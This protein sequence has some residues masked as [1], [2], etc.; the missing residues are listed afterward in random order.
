[1]K[2]L[3]Y[4]ALSNQYGE[5][6][7][8]DGVSKKVFAQCRALESNGFHVNLLA[9]GDDGIYLEDLQNSV[10][11][12]R[13]SIKTKRRRY[14][15]F[16]EATRII[17]ANRIEILYIRYPYCDLAFLKLLKK[18][19]SKV[20]VYV[21]IPSYPIERF[22]VA[23][24]FG[25]FYL[26]KIDKLFAP[27]M[28]K[29]VWEFRIIGSKISYLYGVRCKNILNGIDCNE[30]PIKKIDVKDEEIKLLAVSRMN[31]YHGYDRLLRGLADYYKKEH[32]KRVSLLMVGDGVMKD[33]W[34]ELADSIGIAQYVEF[35]GSKK[36]NELDRFFDIAHIAIDSLG[37]HRVG[38][39]VA[40]TLKSR[41]YCARGIPFVSA[42]SVMGFAED[43]PFIIKSPADE[44]NIDV[45]GLVG[46]YNKMVK[47]Y[48]NY[49]VEMR[50]YAEENLSWDAQMNLCGMNNV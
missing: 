33:K 15:I 26:S 23:S 50:Q 48:P 5:N 34:L 14:S 28:K 37:L 32:G 36:K 42:T 35:T 20:K 27:F 1:M 22:G 49:S 8:S 45:A 9:Y 17:V 41:E 38:F 7:D 29:Y 43:F 10:C 39:N 46:S 3:L 19:K 4:L 16:A 18:A 11:E 21:E 40:A 2:R 30:F 13:S 44:S 6:A 25:N 47:I 24:G 31:D 12:K